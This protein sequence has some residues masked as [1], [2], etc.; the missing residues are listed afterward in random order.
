MTLNPSNW[1]KLESWMMRGHG[2]PIGNIGLS[3]DTRGSVDGEAAP[4]R[5]IQQYLVKCTYLGPRN[6]IPGNASR[7]ILTLVFE[8]RCIKIP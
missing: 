2:R 6:H 7:E 4:F 5:A 3:C 1:P 8:G